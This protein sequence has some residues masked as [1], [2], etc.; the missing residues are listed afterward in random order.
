MQDE[1][2][3]VSVL[4]P[5]KNGGVFFADALRSVLN[6]SYRNIEVL[7]VDDGS[8]DGTID[9]VRNSD[10][11][12]IKLLFNSTPG[13][14][15]V[16]ALNTG[17]AVANGEFVARMDADDI[18]EPDRIS[19]LVALMRRNPKQSAEVVLKSLATRQAG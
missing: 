9:E 3:L 16:G 2:S 5:V 18:C 19:R 15:I 11:T 4:M 13:T 12:R 10:D 1:E 14:G 8:T 17:L 6:Q 7:I